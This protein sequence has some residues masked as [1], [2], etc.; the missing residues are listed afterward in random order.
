MACA[1][2]QSFP[3]VFFSS[4][5]AYVDC[6]QELV[7]T[8]ESTKEAIQVVELSRTTGLT[9]YIPCNKY[10]CTHTHTHTYIHTYIYIWRERETA[11]RERDSASDGRYKGMQ[12][13][14]S[15]YLEG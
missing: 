9:G 10:I 3:D 13:R 5:L 4:C 12:G 7:A 15:W 1:V 2:F 11:D 14:D 6:L 8:A